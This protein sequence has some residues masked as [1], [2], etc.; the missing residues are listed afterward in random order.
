[1]RAARNCRDVGLPSGV[2]LLQTRMAR[3]TADRLQDHEHTEDKLRSC[4]R[5]CPGIDVQV[6]AFGTQPA[7]GQEHRAFEFWAERLRKRPA[8]LRKS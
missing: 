3:R 2:R 8:K 5:M 7:L 4:G 1:M 6:V